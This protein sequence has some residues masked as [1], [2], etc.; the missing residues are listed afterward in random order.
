MERC[1]VL[2]VGGG[3]GGS[4]CA[5][6]LRDSGLDVLVLDRKRFPRHKT[7][8]GW[9]TP[10]VLDE[11]A[12]DS[13]H[14]AKERVFQPI[15][16]FRIRRIGAAEVEVRFEK[17]VS[18]G[19]RR[20]EFDHFLLERC[21]A[22]LRLGEAATR[23]ERAGG[24]WLVNGSIEAPLLVGAGGHFCPVGR[25]LSEAGAEGEPIVAA[26]ELE[27]E[28]DEAGRASCPV[29]PE[30]PEL[31]FTDD[32]KGYGWL[33]RKGDFLNVGLGRQDRHRLS[34]HVARFLEFL[35]AEGKLPHPLPGGLRG[36]AYLLHG[37]APRRLVDD[38]ALLVGD[39]AGLAAPRSGEGIRPA[40]ESGLLAAQ[41]IEEAAGRYDRASLDG[42]RR[43]I[44]E[45]FGKRE[46]R[47]RFG[48]T[49]LLPAP[50]ARRLA[51]KL[52]ATPWFARR[53]VIERWF[54]QAHEPAL[55]A[56]RRP[57]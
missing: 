17:P 35:R 27:F 53:V 30:I 34:D 32:L 20:C 9:I 7:C 48:A 50:L 8:A 22:R 54:V 2:I 12:I 57:G 10:Q 41:R 46:P 38:A 23:I 5:L 24:R 16:G 47:L 1:D 19:I 26:Q 18:Y 45:R 6:G 55:P 28:L 11:L 3:P 4:S 14:Y 51:G 29:E 33:F 56:L 43:A 49:D 40:V 52:L 44:E 31:F 13:E 39:S 15:Q 42:Y 37:Q 36:H 25:R 21:E